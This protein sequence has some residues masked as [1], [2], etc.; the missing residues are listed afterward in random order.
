MKYLEFRLQQQIC[1]WLEIQHPSVLFL[2]DT[3]ANMKLT[4][5][6]QLRNKSIQKSGFH[7]P[8]LIILE[9]KGG[10]HGLFIEL[11]IKSPYKKDGTLLK[12]EHLE[13]QQRSMNELKAKGYYC[14]FAWEFDE[15]IK[16]IDKYLAL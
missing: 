2:S 4:P 7:C 3:I 15:I 16:I 6:A 9:P 5:Q 14:T 10:W 1:K 13:N 8:D 11:K 12:N